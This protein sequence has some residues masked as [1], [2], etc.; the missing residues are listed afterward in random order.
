MA[1]PKYRKSKSKRNMRRSHLALK[2]V[3]TSVCPNC[4]ELKLPHV[5]CGACGH[6]KGRSVIAPKSASKEWTGE[7]LDTKA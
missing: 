2:A 6:Y 4:K 3:G 1:V 7:N 5:I